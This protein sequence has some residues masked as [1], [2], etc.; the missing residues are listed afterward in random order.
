MGMRTG[1]VI[2]AGNDYCNRV[3]VLGRNCD[4]L[5]R[6]KAAREVSGRGG[7]GGGSGDAYPAGYGTVSAYLAQVTQYLGDAGEDASTKY[8]PPSYCTKSV[9]RVGVERVQHSVVR[10]CHGTTTSLITGGSWILGSADG[11]AL[12]QAM[13]RGSQDMWLLGGV[14]WAWPGG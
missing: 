11:S 13:E 5:H 6:V 10:L 2:L 1:T 3:T 8:L 14:A 4:N 12:L 7:G 9:G